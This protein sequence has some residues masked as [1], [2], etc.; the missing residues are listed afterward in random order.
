MNDRAPPPVVPPVPPDDPDDL[1]AAEYALGLLAPADWRAARD[2]A[3]RD[4]RFAARI[5]DWEMRLAPLNTGFPDGPVAP[6]QLA[7]IEARLFPAPRPR[8]RPGL[9]GL[10]SGLLSGAAVVAL[11]LALIL[12]P[13]LRPPAPGPLLAADLASEDGALVFAARFDPQSGAL[14]VTRQGPA[15]AEGRDFQLWAIDDTGVPRSLGLLTA[16]QTRIETALSGGIVLAVSLEPAGGAPGP[17]PTGP[18][19][20]AAPLAG[21]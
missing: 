7:R 5:T 19:L 8:R 12:P 1:L 10:L 20:A 13:L 16:A 4:G 21:P 9:V 3:E 11:A 6:D 17:L 2:R 14:T 18:V 15:A